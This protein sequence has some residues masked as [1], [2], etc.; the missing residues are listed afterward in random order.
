MTRRERFFK[1]M[2]VCAGPALELGAGEGV[3]FEEESAL[4]LIRQN[5]LRVDLIQQRN[6]VQLSHLM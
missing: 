3:V 5:A 1:S 2:A 6:L 4:V